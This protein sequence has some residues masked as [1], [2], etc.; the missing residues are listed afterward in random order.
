MLS[1]SLYD[2]GL[3]KQGLPQSPP[4]T[5]NSMAMWFVIFAAGC[6]IIAALIMASYP[7]TETRFQEIMRDIQDRRAKGIHLGAQTAQRAHGGTDTDAEG[8]PGSQS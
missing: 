7:L 4:E 3:K 1:W 5:L 2:A 6:F 8:G